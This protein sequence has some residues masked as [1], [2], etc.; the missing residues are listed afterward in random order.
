MRINSLKYVKIYFAKLIKL[1]IAKYFLQIDLVY[2][3][4]KMNKRNISNK[5]ELLG[6]YY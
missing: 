5:L 6:L 4:T 1:V 2:I 3:N